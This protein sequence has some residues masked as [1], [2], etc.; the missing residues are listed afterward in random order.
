M[1]FK[2]LHLQGHLKA[3]MPMLNQ[4]LLKELATL[5]NTNSSTQKAVLFDIYT[6]NNI[7]EPGCLNYS[8]NRRF[9]C[10]FGRSLNNCTKVSAYDKEVE[11]SNLK[12]FA[13]KLSAT[14][15]LF[16]RESLITLL[17]YSVL[18]SLTTFCKTSSFVFSSI[19]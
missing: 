15:N 11:C 8:H 9:P 2:P 14:N 13:I 3:P 10:S 1:K 6:L 16:A 4:G 7:Q 17:V 12:P 5:R 19:R 18:A